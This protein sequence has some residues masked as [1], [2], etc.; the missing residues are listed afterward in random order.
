MG[1]V[2]RE[3]LGVL[4]G[5]LEFL[6]DF[7]IQVKPG[8]GDCLVDSRPQRFFAGGRVGVR[9]VVEGDTRVAILDERTGGLEGDVRGLAVDEIGGA[10]AWRA[11]GAR[12]GGAHG[13]GY[14]WTASSSPAS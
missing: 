10:L 9:V 1:R 2:G 12:G 5:V 13:R 7:W 6:R 11:G 3:L 4:N 14:W 8:R